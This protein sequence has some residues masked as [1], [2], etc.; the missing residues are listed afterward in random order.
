MKAEQY[1]EVTDFI[2]NSSPNQLVYL[3]QCISDKIMLFDPDKKKQYEIEEGFNSVVM[4]GLTIQIQI[5]K[6]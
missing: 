4:N 1:R 3:L 2:N 6:Y 5:K